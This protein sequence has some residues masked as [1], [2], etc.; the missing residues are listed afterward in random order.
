MLGHL[1]ALG[2]TQVESGLCIRLL[3]EPTRKHAFA[4]ETVG[5]TATKSTH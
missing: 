5:L 1:G 2:F 3:A 4:A